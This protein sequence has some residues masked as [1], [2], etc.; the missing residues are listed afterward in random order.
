M[1]NQQSIPLREGIRKRQILSEA[2][3]KLFISFFRRTELKSKTLLVREGQICDEMYYI[4][5]GCV[6]S[7]QWVGNKQVTLWFGHEGDFITCFKSWINN[8]PSH[9]Y[10][11]PVEDCEIYLIS[12]KDFF[13]LVNEN[14]G[15]HHFYRVLLEEGYLYWENRASL[16][17][18]K[19]AEEK[20][21]ALLKRAPKAMS[22]YPLNQIASYLGITQ[23][24]LSRLRS[25]KI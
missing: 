2:D 18:F 14:P 20:L 7:Y 11:E 24:T 3:E 10:I 6:V 17:L 8:V 13:Q 22:R 15:I 1:N 5:R 12:R 23:E 4:A 16:L 19:S 9:E 25:K 21:A